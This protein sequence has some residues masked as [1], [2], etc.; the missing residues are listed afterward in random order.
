MTE[1]DGKTGVNVAVYLLSKM[2]DNITENGWSLQKIEIITGSRVVGYF[3]GKG[4]SNL[5]LQAAHDIVYREPTEEDLR[6]LGVS[7]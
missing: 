4:S 5:K 6:L 7:D 3:E 1:E 2:F